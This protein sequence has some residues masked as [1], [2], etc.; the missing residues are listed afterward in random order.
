M[1]VNAKN[2]TGNTGADRLEVQKTEVQKTVVQKTEVQKT[3]ETEVQKYKN[4]LLARCRSIID[5]EAVFE[6]KDPEIQ[7][8]KRCDELHNYAQEYPCCRY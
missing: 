7:E 5:L 6:R 4:L 2:N 3:E 8:K 1:I